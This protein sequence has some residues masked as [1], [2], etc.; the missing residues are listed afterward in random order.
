MAEGSGN[1]GNDILRRLQESGGKTQQQLCTGMQG[2]ELEDHD[3]EFSLPKV[4]VLTVLLNGIPFAT[5]YAVPGWDT[6]TVNTVETVDG[7]FSLDDLVGAIQ[8]G[9]TCE[10]IRNYLT[11]YHRYLGDDLLGKLNGTAEGI[12]AFFYV[13]ETRD[14]E[15]V[16]LWANYGADVNTTYGKMRI[17][18]LA[19]AIALGTSFTHDTTAVVKT[20]L[21]LGASVNV[22]PKACYWPLERD[23]PRDGPPD[24]ELTELKDKEKRWCVPSARRRITTTLNLSFTQRYVL[25]LASYLARFSEATRQVTRLHEADELLGI[26]YFLIWADHGIQVSDRQTRGVSCNANQEAYCAPLCG[27]KR[28]CTRRLN[29]FGPR[30]PFIGSG[31][32]SALNN[33]I[34]AHNGKRSIIFMFLDEFEKTEHEIRQ[35]LLIPF[36]SGEYQDRRNLR[37]LD[38][39][40]SIW[41][42]ATNAFDPTIHSFCR[43]NE[44][45][46]ITGRITDFLPFLTFSPCEE[47]AVADKALAKEGYVQ[48]L[49]ARS[50]IN[51][52][53]QKVKFPFIGAYLET[54]EEIREGQPTSVFVLGVG[55]DD[56]VEVPQSAAPE[57]AKDLS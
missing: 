14:S 33:L 2:L 19:F 8:G 57:P 21:S 55:D 23:L 22:I 11:H 18:L 56:E 48:E 41:I 4:P 29:L 47:A 45:A 28:P 13:I 24:D 34:A 51:I 1:Q 16:R 6:R 39:S 3:W 38:C 35:T 32:G 26:Q 49:G 40:K 12:P 54:R 46:P 10:R 30:A 9:E 15:L 31:V 37:S 36:Q 27:P 44:K 5:D 53:D 42:L 52:V 50:V 25:H 7:N 43:Q 20:L 17:P